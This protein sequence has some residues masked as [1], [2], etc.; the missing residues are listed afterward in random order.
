LI[1]AF[2]FA[3]ATAG[4]TAPSQQAASSASSEVFLGLFV[5][6]VAAK[7]GEE[8]ARRLGQPAVVGE[9]LGGVL[10]G[11]YAL[12][13]AQ[14]TEPA[15]VFS[16]FGVVI[17][18]FAVGLEVRIDDL[19]AVGRPAALTA[20]IGMLLPIAGGYAVGI[21]IGSPPDSAIY[22]G[23][24]LAATS[25][26][27]TSRVLA[28]LGVLDRRFSRVILGAAVI[29]DILVLI[30]IGVVEGFTTGDR[31]TSAIGLVISAVGLLGL[32]FLAARRARGLPREVFTWPRFAET[33]LVVAFIFM[34]GMALLSAYL[35]LAAIIGAFV[36]GLIIAETEAREEIEHEI[37]P[38]SVIFTPFFFAFTGAQLDLRTLADP[39]VVALVVALILVGVVT[40]TVGGLIGAW[41]TGRWSAT[42]V[43]FGM[44]PRG[45][46]GIVVANLGLSSGLLSP[47]SF[48]AVLVAVIG[49]TIVAP[50][51]LAFA[52]PHAIREEGDRGGDGVAPAPKAAP[53]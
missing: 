48:S 7:I 20:V 47:T 31:S 32:G 34:F 42:T 39:A 24:A 9:L 50:Y 2:A 23:L 28:E 38:L 4:A 16:E 44:S 5:L 41:S 49:T 46:V 12:G 40:K 29:D 6:F 36:A 10:V 30:A 22:V 35:G 43:G 27:I 1:P 19:L 17:L 15:A 13:W 25:I 37:R 3:I 26:G 11:P 21:A 18:L 14:L 53:A 33:P 51:L 52:I 8:V 45:E